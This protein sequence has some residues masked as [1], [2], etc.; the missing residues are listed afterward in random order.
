MSLNDSQKD[1][2]DLMKNFGLDDESVECLAHQQINS[3]I[4][5]VITPKNKIRCYCYIMCNRSEIFKKMLK[6]GIVTNQDLLECAKFFPPTFNYLPSQV[7]SSAE[8]EELVVANMQESWYDFLPYNIANRTD[9]QLKCN[10]TRRIYSEQGLDS[11]GYNRDWI[12]NDGKLLEFFKLEA[13][14]PIRTKDDYYKL[15]NEYLEAKTSIS[16]FCNRYCISP[17]QGFK[18][19]LNRIKA[20]SLED[21]MEIKV[22]GV[23]VSQRFY[24]NAKY[25]A[26]QLASRE[27]SPEEFFSNQ[28]INFDTNN[29][30]LYFNTLTPEERQSLAKVIFNYVEEHQDFI[31]RGLYK[32]LKSFENKFSDGFMKFVRR[33]LK[34]TEDIEIIRKISNHTYKNVKSHDR[35]YC[36]KELYCNYIVGDKSVTVDDAIIEQALSYADD[37]GIYKSARA[38]YYLCKRIAFGELN[39]FKESEDKKDSLV[40]S[41]IDLIEQNKGMDSYISVIKKRNAMLSET[42]TNSVKR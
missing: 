32:F 15:Y 4:G 38:M 2:L 29:A 24:A 36:R 10:R 31:P 12:N 34:P 42:E 13:D 17:E 14:F 28:K 26:K 20:E 7:F 40:E 6:G 33:N 39:Y 18:N 23:N 1:K 16:V 5:G 25:Y 8:F 30:A 27:M 21:A 3:M 9:V 22:V 11:E 35:I 19:L 41:I 37:K